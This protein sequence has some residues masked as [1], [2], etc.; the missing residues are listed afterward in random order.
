L[1]SEKPIFLH[2]GGVPVRL[3]FDN[4]SI[5]VTRILRKGNRN[6]TDEFLRF[7]EHFG[8]QSVFFNTAS[9]HEKGSVKNKI[10][11]HRRNLCVPLTEFKSLEAYN[12]E[13]LIRCDEDNKR[14][15]YRKEQCIDQLFLED[16]QA[17]G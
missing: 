14:I 10:G 13:L 7:Q 2:I 11:Y 16:Q 17:F 15:H 5:F 6:L 9:G 1:I 12:E 8:F 3:W 4:A